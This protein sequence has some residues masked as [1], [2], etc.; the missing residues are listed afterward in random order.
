MSFLQQTA[1]VWRGCDDICHFNLR[2]RSESKDT[3]C[4]NCNLCS[5]ACAEEL[6]QC[7]TLFHLTDST[8]ASRINAEVQDK[9]MQGGFLMGY[10][11]YSRGWPGL[12]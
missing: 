7:N 5:E 6:G 9:E 2:T 12:W 10:P 1:P 3:D 4:T 8:P 11:V